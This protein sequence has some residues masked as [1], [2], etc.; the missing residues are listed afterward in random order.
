MYSRTLGRICLRLRPCAVTNIRVNTGASEIPPVH[1]VFNRNIVSKSESIVSQE[2]CPPPRLDVSSKRLV[3]N[4]AGVEEEYPWVWLRDSC[5]CPLCYD[6][7]SQSRIINLTEWDLNIKPAAVKTLN[8]EIE[9]TWEDGHV[10]V[11][12]LDWLA[13]RSF[14]REN[15]ERFRRSVSQPQ[16][17]W[18]RELLDNVPT[19]DYGEVMK[20]DAA[21]LDWLENLD[22]FGFVLVRNVPVEEGPV[23]ALQKRVAFEKMTHYGPG[24]TVVVRADPANISHTHHRIFFHTDLTYYD[25]MAGAV[26]LHCIEQHRGDGGETML[27]D[28]FH[29]AALLKTKHPEMYKLLSETVTHFRDVGTDYTQFDKISHQSFLIHNT[30][31]ELQRIN[32]SHFARDTHLDVDLDKVDDLYLAMRTFDDLMNNE[33]N[34]IRLKMAPG[35]MVTVKNQRILHGRS[36]L[37]GGVSGRHLQCGYMDWDEIRSA[38]R[39]TRTKLGLSL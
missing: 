22:R 30:R 16:V 1:N 38:I 34:H 25:Y 7:L 21:L 31:G 11:F 5:P 24:Y 12:S 10:S 33:E 4:I 37:Q 35:D 29:A 32:W 2:S 9:I 28:G 39:V 23:P 13:A 36:E 3:V 17:L 8:S 26:F 27:T 15:R 14:R 20:S 19:A 18:G 6:P